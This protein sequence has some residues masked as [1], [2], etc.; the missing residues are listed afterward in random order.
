MLSGEPT[1]KGTGL[2]APAGKEDPVEFDSSLM[3][4]NDMGG[5][6]QVG[7]PPS[8]PCGDAAPRRV[9]GHTHIMVGLRD[10]R[11]PAGRT[12]SEIPLPSPSF[13]SASGLGTAAI[14]HRPPRPVRGGRGPI[15]L[16]VP[17]AWPRSPPGGRGPRATHGALNAPPHRPAPRNTDQLGSLAGAARLLQDNAGVLKHCSDGREI[18]HGGAGQRCC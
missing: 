14:G 16:R 7:G 11:V 17:S 13:Y 18:L 6:A 3:L 10:A 9:C 1:A 12:G 2:G 4:C 8:P 15:P 5:V